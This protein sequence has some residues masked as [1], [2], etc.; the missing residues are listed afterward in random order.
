VSLHHGNEMTWQ[1]EFGITILLKIDFKPNSTL[2]N[3]FVRWSLDL[4]IN[5]WNV[6]SLVD[7]GYTPSSRRDSST[8]AWNLYVR[9]SDS[10]PIRDGPISPTT[11]LGYVFDIILEIN[12]KP[13]SI[14]QNWLVR[15]CFYLFINY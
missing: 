10:G 2:Q 15:W 13:N 5:H 9:W 14:L 11:L 1:E 4:F 6:L 8:L 3:W 7:V 12:F